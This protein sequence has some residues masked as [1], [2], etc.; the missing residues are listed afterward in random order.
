[1]LRSAV[2]LQPG[3]QERPTHQPSIIID[4]PVIQQFDVENRLDVRLASL[5]KALGSPHQTICFDPH[6]TV[7]STQGTVTINRPVSAKERRQRAAL[8]L[9]RAAAQ[10]AVLHVVMGDDDE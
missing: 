7:A 8:Q 1:M 2:L 9:F 5:L 4:A 10:F 6:Q 3:L